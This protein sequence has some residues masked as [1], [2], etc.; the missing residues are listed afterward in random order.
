MSL[1]P[2]S[3]Q[4]IPAETARVARAAFP[5]GNI[6][7]RLRDE[8]GPI[9]EDAQFAHLF[10]WRGQPGESP[11]QLILVSILQ[12]IEGLS[13][14]QTTEMMR[15]RI[16]WKYLLGLAL[17]DSGF[18]YSVL[19]EFRQRLVEGSAEQQLLDHF[20]RLVGNLGL[21]KGRGRQRTD[22][23]HVLAAVRQLNRIEFV[24]ESLRQA[25][26]IV[27]VVA[28]DWL[29]SWVPLSWYERYSPRSE[30]YRLPTKAVEQGIWLQQV[31]Q[32]GSTLLETIRQTEAMNWLA[33]VEAVDHLRQIWMQQ[34]YRDEAGTRLRQAEKEGL[35][36]HKQLIVSPHDLEAR[37]RTKRETNWSGYAVHMTESCDTDLPHL[38]TD[39]QTTPATVGDAPLLPI[40]HQALAERDLLPAE[41][42]VDT[43][44]VSAPHL[45]DSQKKEID[46][47]GPVP[48][49]NSWQAR[50]PE[51]FPVKCFALNWE[52]Q[53]ATCPQGQQSQSWKHRHPGQDNAYVEIAFPPTVCRDCA[54]R[55]QC[56]R[57][58]K[59]GRVLRLQPQDRFEMVQTRRQRQES[60]A[61]KK[62][63]QQRAG[64]EGTLSQGV[65]QMDLRHA[66]YIGLQ[67]TGLQHILTAIAIN[68][69]RLYA[70][71]ESRPRAKTR[72][73]HFATLAPCT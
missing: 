32:D 61:F 30:A 36:P 31:G 64:I 22:S 59:R 9:Y 7:L 40:I 51:A 33:K 10:A 17:E 15:G 63:Y 11:V 25:L 49:D 73:T 37:N 57:T 27:A 8:L 5:K 69:K 43:A 14:R 18:D 44:Y 62:A 4:T 3:P 19:S 2:R 26:E 13:D 47:I 6:Y 52:A 39:V 35:P 38:I 66:R 41:H 56:T 72:V 54:V 24:T 42:L 67:K 28:P 16:D 34:Y 48:A 50:T 23:T 21:V 70:W 60:A 55:Q 12:Y 65:R 71:F 53:I 46:L 68:F 58:Q 29:Q 20:L 45:V 1:A